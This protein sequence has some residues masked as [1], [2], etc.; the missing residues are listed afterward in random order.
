MSTQYPSGR[1]RWAV[2]A[3]AL[4]AL[5][6]LMPASAL[7]SDRVGVIVQMQPG[8]SPE[9]VMAQ[10]RADGGTVTDRLDVVN[11]FAATIPASVQG[12]LART[13]GVREVTRNGSVEPQGVD[14]SKL[15]TAFP[16]S[17]NAPQAWN[18][19]GIDATGRGVGVAVIDTGIDSDLADFRDANGDSRVVASAV[20]N[21]D[22]TTD[23]DEYGHGTHVAGILAG[24]SWRRGYDDDARGR[25]LGIAPNAN[26]VSVKV[27]DDDGN[28]TVLDVI[29]GLQFVVDH[30]D[31]YNIRV[32]NLS[33]EAA[34]PGSYKT[35]PLDAAVENAWF[36]GIV[37][38]A[39]AGN[40]GTAPDA[41]S[42]APG[43]D[44]YA[45]T[46]GA[47]DDGASKADGDDARPSWSSRGIT[48]DGFIKPEVHAP[49]AGIVSNLAK[50]SKFAQMCASCVVDGNMIRAGGT[51]MAAPVV[52]GA[53]ALM[54]Q[55]APQLT[56]DQVKGLLI[57][58]SRKLNGKWPEIDLVGTGK[59]YYRGARPTANL[60]LSP[61]LLVDS[62][63][64]L[65]DYTRSSWSRSSWSRSSWSRSS[66]SCADCSEDS[67]DGVLPSRSSWSRSSWSMSWSK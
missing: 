17:I 22:A 34:N 33:L 35:D 11:G 13:A 26:L 12:E 36:N 44:P 45:I 27:S 24:N 14:P 63:S 54:L 29:R 43:N 15:K 18:G 65:I 19:Y 51:S 47:V 56:P 5:I 10:V 30:K 25:Y 1:I 48:R 3:L 61:N 7:A 41:V 32:V 59:L 39:A 2:L 23:Q 37:V 9:A 50:H 67:G 6:A 66:W 21:P 31:D 52:A 42:Y 60:G 57:A 49:G 4:L 46:V 53:V 28:T 38:V 58:G 8:L 64:G 40:R 55:K 20:V 62:A 16:A